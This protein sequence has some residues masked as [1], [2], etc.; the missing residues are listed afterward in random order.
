MKKLV[1]L[2][3]I[4]VL[5]MSAFANGLSLNSIGPKALSMG[6]AFVALADDGTAI[7]WNPAGLVDQP[8]M[9]NLA[10]TDIVPIGTYYWDVP[11]WG[12]FNPNIDAEMEM[13][14]YISPNLF[15]NMS[16]GN[17]AL[18]LGVFVPAGLGAEWNGED[19]KNLSAGQ[20]LDWRS[21]IGVID[22]PGYCL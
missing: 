13:N 11:A 14:H 20:S 1:L 18:G 5:S 12:P 15:F 10:A 2:L 8:T 17:L 22:C 9:I 16:K 3:S 21:K 7:Y 19:L 6:G 4:L